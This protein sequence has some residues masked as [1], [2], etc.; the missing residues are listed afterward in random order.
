MDIASDIARALKDARRAAGLSQRDLAARIGMP[1]S[2]LSKIE[3]GRVDAQVSTVIEIARALGHD[4]RLVPRQGIAILESILPKSSPADGL[5]ARALLLARRIDARKPPFD[6]MADYRRSRVLDALRYFGHHSIG[7]RDQAELQG[8]LKRLGRLD[9]LSPSA[10]PKVERLTA[11]LIGLMNRVHFAGDEQ[12]S[13]AIPAYQLEEEG[14][15]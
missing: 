2:H 7:P 15:A 14:D 5:Q 3:S 1:Q 8:V 6:R 4:L 13:R 11:A 10:R 9:H 12:A